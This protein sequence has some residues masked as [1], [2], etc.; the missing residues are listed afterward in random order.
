MILRG[1]LKSGE[2]HDRYMHCTCTI[3]CAH[4]TMGN[5]LSDSFVGC[6]AKHIM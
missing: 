4:V 1:S 2:R 6:G 5:S 3:L